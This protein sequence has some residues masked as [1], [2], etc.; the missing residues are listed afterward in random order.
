MADA[1]RDYYWLD[2]VCAFHT[3]KHRAQQEVVASKCGKRKYEKVSSA[4][5]LIGEKV[6][7]STDVQ[8]VTWTLNTLM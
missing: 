4:R 5:C 1:Q 7:E 3:R 2:N 8:V 6:H